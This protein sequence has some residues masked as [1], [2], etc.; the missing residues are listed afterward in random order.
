ST[1]CS[2]PDD[3]STK[4]TSSKT[5]TVTVDSNKVID[6][7]KVKEEEAKKKAEVAKKQAS[8][9]AAERDKVEAAKKAKS[10]T[11]A[12]ALFASLNCK[13]I[14]YNDLIHGNKPAKY[15]KY[16][17]LHDTEGG[18]TPE[19]VISGWESAG[20]G[21]AAHFV[22]GRDGSIAQSVPLDKIGHHAGYGNGGFNKKYGI[23]DDGRDDMKGSVSIGSSYPDYGMNAW[24]IGIELIHNGEADYPEAQLKRLDALIK[25]LDAYYANTTTG[26]AGKI[27]QHKDW[28]TT[29]SDCS[30][31][32]Q[33]YLSN[34]QS[35]R[36]YK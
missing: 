27:I 26:N 6:Q 29:N 30:N 34:Y 17:V 18:G 1:A 4:S 36:S 7:E 13:Q 28:R 19:G 3:K 15:Q 20:S 24:S 12:K 32:F 35:K 2:S 5:K 8:Q 25:Y 21:V 33:G 23:S 14:F 31:E 10:K 9:K 16:I 11:N 22:I